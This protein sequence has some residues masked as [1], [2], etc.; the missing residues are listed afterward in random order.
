MKMNLA[1]YVHFTSLL[2]SNIAR[3]DEQANIVWRM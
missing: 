3:V 2:M 1:I